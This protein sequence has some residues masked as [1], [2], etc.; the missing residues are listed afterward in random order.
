[1]TTQAQHWSKA[2]ASYEAD[3][4]DPY[5]KDVRNPLR[6]RLRKL[7][8]PRHGVVADLGCGIGPLLPDLARQFRNVHAVDFAEGMLGRARERCA[9]LKNVTFHHRAL[10]D[11]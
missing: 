4:I 2:A 9:D 3:F 10:T 7:A 8:E 11:L 1:M 5:R 6:A